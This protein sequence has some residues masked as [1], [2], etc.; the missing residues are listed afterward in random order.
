MTA[1]P[2]AISA[3]AAGLQPDVCASVE[4]IGRRLDIELQNVNALDL[5]QTRDLAKRVS[6]GFSATGRA[7]HQWH[8]SALTR[9]SAREHELLAGSNEDTTINVD[10][11][12][13]L[14]ASGGAGSR[15]SRER[16]Y[17]ERTG[18]RRHR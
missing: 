8:N 4:G 15:T 17:W 13:R 3:G 14:I 18:G 2:L 10:T 7:A 12:T 1:H 11:N 6:A 16:S 9:L 5:A